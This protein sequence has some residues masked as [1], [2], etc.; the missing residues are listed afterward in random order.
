VKLSARELK[1]P[2]AHVPLD[3]FRSAKYPACDMVTPGGVTFDLR[4]FSKD[5]FERFR[6]AVLE[7]NGRRGGS[8]P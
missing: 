5:D 1:V 3:G 7:G 6:N 4:K 2:D 8:T